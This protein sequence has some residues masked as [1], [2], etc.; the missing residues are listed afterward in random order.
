MKKFKKMGK[1]ILSSL[2][3]MAIAIGMFATPTPVNAANTNYSIT[4]KTASEITSAVASLLSSASSGDTITVTGSSVLTDNTLSFAIPSGV[5]IIWQADVEGTFS[6]DGQALI[7]ISGAGNFKV[8]TGARI[9]ATRVGGL[10]IAIVSDGFASLEINGGTISAFSDGAGARAIRNASSGSIQVTGG[11]IS[12]TGIHDGLSN[13]LATIWSDGNT[14]DI[15]ISGGSITATS[16]NTN[17]G[18]AIRGNPAVNI[19]VTGGNLSGNITSFALTL[20]LSGTI[21]GNFSNTGN[22]FMLDT[23]TIP[24]SRN[25][26]T[27]GITMHSSSADYANRADYKWD[28]TR[29]TPYVVKTGTDI[30]QWGEYPALTITGTYNIPATTIGTAITPIDVSAGVS[31]GRT[32]YTY[33]ATGLPAGITI[34]S[35]TG[36]ISGTPTAIGTGTAT[37]TATD[38]DGKTKNITITYTING[39]NYSIV[40]GA[41]ATWK[42]GTETG[43]TIK[44]DGAFAKFTGVEV[45]GTVIDPSNYTVEDGSTIVTLKKSYLDGLGAGTYNIKILFSDGSSATT[46]I[47]QSASTTNPKTSD[48]N[49]SFMIISTLLAG[50]VGIITYRKYRKQEQN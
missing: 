43:L 38:V 47:V 39:I 18:Y 1:R 40:T 23:L 21:T 9:V 7:Y 27:T 44:S 46:F 48:I 34:N 8:V 17:V 25:G 36:I 10:V 33:S 20:Y 3:V 12:A 15:I 19:T 4:G 11:S 22:L 41:N 13:S 50:A 42:K 2:M 37:I 5:T 31:G 32:P 29:S 16:T 26:T 28:T 24:Q 45:N 49:L 35:G 30:F 14:G 6:S